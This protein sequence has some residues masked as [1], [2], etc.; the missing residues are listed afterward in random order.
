VTMAAWDS[1][2]A[3]ILRGRYR[4]T[5]CHKQCFVPCRFTAAEFSEM[6]LDT[7]EGSSESEGSSGGP[8]DLK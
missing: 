5:M 8:T 6:M 4:C 7:D 1:V 2:E 3:G